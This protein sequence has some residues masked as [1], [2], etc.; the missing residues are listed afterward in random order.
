MKTTNLNLR[1]R[2]FHCREIGVDADYGILQFKFKDTG[3]STVGTF[4]LAWLPQFKANA[5]NLRDW[6]KENTDAVKW[7]RLGQ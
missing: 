3:F 1:F 4:N 5:D 6:L 2:W 7:A